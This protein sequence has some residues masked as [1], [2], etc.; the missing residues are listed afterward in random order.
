MQP[1]CNRWAASIHKAVRNQ[2]GAAYC[3]GK[4]LRAYV[5]LKPDARLH[6]QQQLPLYMYSIKAHLQGDAASAD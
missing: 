3:R 5:R 1:E 2:C 6:V 4:S